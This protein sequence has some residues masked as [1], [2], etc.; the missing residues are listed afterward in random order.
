M[1]IT[2]TTH[3]LS[4]YDD[5]DEDLMSDVIAK[6]MKK[7]TGAPGD[8]KSNMQKIDDLIAAL[9]TDKASRAKYTATLGTTWTGGAAPYTQEVAVQGLLATDE[10]VKVDIDY[11]DTYETALQQEEE[12]AKV[13]RADIGAG[14]LTFYAKEQTTVSLNLK[15]AVVR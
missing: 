9:E 7:G 4:V 13:Y 6:A 3:G 8:P 14:K 11:S 15:I 1:A 2:T 12:W 5:P 10:D